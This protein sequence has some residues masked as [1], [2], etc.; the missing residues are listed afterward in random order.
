VIVMRPAMPQ[1]QHRFTKRSTVYRRMLTVIHLRCNPRFAFVEAKLMQMKLS[2]GIGLGWLLS[3]ILRR[4]AT[5]TNT[6]GKQG[7]ADRTSEMKQ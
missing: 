5:V 1:S 2:H 4:S 3:M 7:A 6:Q